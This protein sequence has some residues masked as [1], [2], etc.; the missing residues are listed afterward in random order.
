MENVNSLEFM[1]NCIHVLFIIAIIT[2]PILII[3][4]FVFHVF[5]NPSN[6]TKTK[7]EDHDTHYIYIEEK[8]G[9][10]DYTDDYIWIILA[11]VFVIW[12]FHH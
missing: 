3:V 12:I 2:I 7:N 10:T 11:M 4:S 9:K 5:E 8:Q 6:D 1:E